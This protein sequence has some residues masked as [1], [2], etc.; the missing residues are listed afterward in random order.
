M[1]VGFPVKERRLNEGRPLNARDNDE[2][3]LRA[4]RRDRYC[5]ATGKR[6]RS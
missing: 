2:L 6:R 1:M 3:N 5:N 4:D